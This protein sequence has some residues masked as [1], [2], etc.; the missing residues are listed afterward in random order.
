MVSVGTVIKTSWMTSVLLKKRKVEHMAMT[1]LQEMNSMLGIKPSESNRYI[2]IVLAS[3]SKLFLKGMSSLLKDKIE[4]IKITTLTSFE[5]IGRSVPS[6]KPEI[7]F[8]DNTTLKHEVQKLLKFVTT[9]SPDT[10]VILF[11]PFL[12]DKINL[13][14]VIL[15]GKDADSSKLISIIKE[16]QIEKN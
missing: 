3:G 15:L 6:L 10:N 11:S 4:N 7:L 9:N 2:Q 1:A 8:V 12:I 14:N 13:P 5:D 16:C